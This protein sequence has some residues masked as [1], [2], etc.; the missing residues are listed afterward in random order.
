M[1]HDTR[2]SSSLLLLTV[3]AAASGVAIAAPVHAQQ[4]E[5]YGVLVPIFANSAGGKGNF[6]KDIA[7][8]FRKLLEDFPTHKPV[9]DNDVRDKLKEFGLKEEALSDAGNDCVNAQQLTAHVHARLVLC[10]HWEEVAKD[11][12]KVSAKVVA[13]GGESYTMTDFQTEDAKQA[14]Q[15]LLSQFDVYM[16]GLRDA[17]YCQEKVTA[18]VW[19]EAVTKCTDALKANPQSKSAAYNLGSAYWRS[20]DRD[21]AAEMFKKVLDLDPTYDDAIKA[22]GIIAAEQGRTDDATRYFHEYLTFN[23]GDVAVRLS[24]ATE[25]AQA[26]GYDAALKIVEDGMDQTEGDDL[27]ALKAFAGAVSMNAALKAM[28]A[29]ENPSEVGDARPVVEKGLGYLEDVYA[30]KGAEMD[31]TSLRNMFT[32]YRLLDQDAKAVELGR[33]AVEHHPDDASIWS[34]YADALNHAGSTAEALA[35]L[36]KV[37]AIDPQYANLYLRKALWQLA[38]NNFEGTV[39]AAQ[40]GLQK[41]AIAPEQVDQIAQQITNAGYQ[42]ARA[43]DYAGALPYYDTAEKVAQTPETKA[44]IAFFRGYSVYQ[45]AV[46]REKPENV[47]TARATLPQFKRA[48]ALMEAAAAYTK[49]KPLEKNRQE[50]IDGATQLIEIQELIIKKGR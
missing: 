3:L 9:A 42:K 44:M 22:L 26:G 15:Q 16:A 33:M 24:I 12:Y 1:I 4:G 25:A 48:I 14:A 28:N 18:E 29:S 46:D 39:V 7:K 5:R 19:S 17:V 35:A 38:T 41:N 36:D 43:G 13:P 49:G 21:K 30:A 20:G 37:A 6:G 11:M 23:P 40:E 34:N 2:R 50:I 32:A 27:V 47:A 31:V 10:G 45:I 8:E